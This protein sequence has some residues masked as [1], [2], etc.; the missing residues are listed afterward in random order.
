MTLLIDMT[1]V[2]INGVRVTGKAAEMLGG[3]PSWVCICACGLEFIAVGSSL[4]A[5][6]TKSCPPCTKSRVASVATKHKAIGSPEYVTY[7]AMKARCY[8]ER[9]KRFARYG[10]RGIRVCQRWL[11]SFN[12]FLEDMAPKPSA[13]HSI[14]RIDVDGNYEPGNCVWATRAEQANNKS[15]NTRIEICGRVQTI[16][17]WSQETGV[18]RTVILRRMQRGLSGDALIHKGPLK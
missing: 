11:E 3:R 18:N 8:Y 15:N 4:R 10:G 16:T 9:D 7:S 1:G 12:N 13:R 6:K 5:G 2:E 17:Q 14:E